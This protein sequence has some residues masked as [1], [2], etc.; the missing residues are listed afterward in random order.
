VTTNPATY[1]FKGD[2]F[3]VRAKSERI[4]RQDGLDAAG[5]FE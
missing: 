3:Y 5:L 2:E 4:E 1:A